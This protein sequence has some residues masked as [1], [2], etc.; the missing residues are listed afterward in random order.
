MDSGL[1]S[2]ISENRLEITKFANNVLEVISLYSVLRH[3]FDLSFLISHEVSILQYTLN[4]PD[5][6]LKEK[7]ETMKT[8]IKECWMKPSIIERITHFSLELLTLDDVIL[9]LKCMNEIYTLL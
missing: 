9:S 1:F 4:L 7:L 3:E 5:L 2:I 8:L 6:T